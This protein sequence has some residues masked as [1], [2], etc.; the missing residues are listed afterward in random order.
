MWA[1]H[2]EDNVIGKAKEY[3]GKNGT[4]HDSWEGLWNY[5][6]QKYANRW[7]LASEAVNNFLFKSRPS[8]DKRDTANYIYQQ[9]NNLDQ[10][11][12]LGL[13]IEEIGVNTILQ[14]L[15][16]EHAKEIRQALRTAHAGKSEKEHFKNPNTNSDN[17]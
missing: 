13:T 14:N 17:Q 5:L 7:N 15:P 1:T 4:W 6:D 10:I 16:E 11:L 3:I 8:G 9:K 12:A 2:L